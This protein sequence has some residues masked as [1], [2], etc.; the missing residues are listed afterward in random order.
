MGGEQRDDELEAGPEEP[1]RA[2]LRPWSR[3]A[4]TFAAILWPSF[5]AAALATMLCFAFVDPEHLGEFTTPPLE[6]SRT[7]SYGLGFFFFWFVAA[8]SSAVS[9]Y[10]VRTAN[11]GAS[12][13]TDRNGRP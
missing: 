3:A 4:Q 2:P 10:L 7:V 5:L 11:P 13:D 8:I 6:L 12:A 1:W 9:V